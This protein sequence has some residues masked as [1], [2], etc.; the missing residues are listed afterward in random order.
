MCV[1]FSTSSEYFL[2]N[3]FLECVPLYMLHLKC[4]VWV[5]TVCSSFLTRAALV[6]N[7]RSYVYAKR[8]EA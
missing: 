8:G 7:S 6:A 1:Y 2:A 5:P 3:L 4:L